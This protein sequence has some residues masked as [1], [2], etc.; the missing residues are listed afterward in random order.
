MADLSDGSA[1]GRHDDVRELMDQLG[2]PD[3][4]G[5][6]EVSKRPKS[7]KRRRQVVISVRFTAEELEVV[8]AGARR[9]SVPVGTY[10]RECALRNTARQAPS[11]AV[12]KWFEPANIS[13]RPRD[14]DATFGVETKIN[15]NYAP[16]YSLNLRRPS[17]K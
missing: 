13:T 5:T 7:E 2:D 14:T 6:P 1:A 9:E 4:W 10:L 8:E 12:R 16:E 17:S 11:G 15:L 3:E